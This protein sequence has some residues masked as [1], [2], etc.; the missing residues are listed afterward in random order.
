MLLSFFKF[1]QLSLRKLPSLPPFLPQR[2]FGLAVLFYSG[3]G[4]RA[5][6]QDTAITVKPIGLFQGH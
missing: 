6:S 3:S 2:G 1:K 5:K 4:A